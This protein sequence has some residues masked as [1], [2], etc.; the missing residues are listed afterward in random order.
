LSEPSDSSSQSESPRVRRRSVGTEQGR[1]AFDDSTNIATSDFEVSSDHDDDDAETTQDTPKENETT[2]RPK[3]VV[4]QFPRARLTRFLRKM[5]RQQ[6]SSDHTVL[7][8][9][10]FLGELSDDDADEARALFD[11][12]KRNLKKGHES[13][14]HV[15]TLTRLFAPVKQWISEEYDFFSREIENVSQSKQLFDD[16]EMATEGVDIDQ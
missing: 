15:D 3:T 11:L 14:G 16:L 9:E 5:N 7:H 2:V 10:T 1:K 13:K 6:S 4:V 12:I 8:L